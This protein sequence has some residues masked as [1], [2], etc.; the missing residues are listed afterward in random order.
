VGRL[1]VEALTK[2]GHTDLARQAIENW[3]HGPEP[4]T[5]IVPFMKWWRW[6]WHKFRRRRCWLVAITANLSRA[7]S[8]PSTIETVWAQNDPGAAIDWAQKLP[9]PAGREDA[10]ANVLPVG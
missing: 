9:Q 2:A 3:A 1:T 10:V 8:S 4:L 7:Q 6:P 5:S